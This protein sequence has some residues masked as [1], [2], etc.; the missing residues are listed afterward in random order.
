[1][2]EQLMGRGQ[3][4]SSSRV[5]GPPASKKSL[6]QPL[7]SGNTTPPWEVVPACILQRKGSSLKNSVKAC[8]WTVEGRTS[9]G[10]VGVGVTMLTEPMGIPDSIFGTKKNPTKP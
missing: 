5:T 3:Q 10:D 1:M 2:Y 4:G 9:T 7:V 6:M 8:G